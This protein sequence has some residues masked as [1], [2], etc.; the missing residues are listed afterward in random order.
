MITQGPSRTCVLPT[1]G[2]TKVQRLEPVND[3]H[4]SI[5][6]QEYIGLT[7]LRI[8]FTYMEQIVRGQLIIFKSQ[9]NL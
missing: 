7:N 5:D 9:T 8:R 2:F 3:N 1:P 4:V 6:L